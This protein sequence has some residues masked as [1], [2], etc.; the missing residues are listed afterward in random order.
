[1]DIQKA[2]DLIEKSE[3]IALLM[4]KDAS[5]DCL[6][7]AEVLARALAKKGKQTG[8]TGKDPTGSPIPEVFR[9]LNSSSDLPREFIVSLDTG[10]SP[11]SQLRYEKSENR[12]DIILS[13]KESS[14]LRDSISF[15]DGKTICDCIVSINVEN[16]EE[17]AGTINTDPD[18]FTATPIIN[19]DNGAAKK[20]YGEAN[21]VDGSRSSVS[22]LIYQFLSAAYES[23]LDPDSATI[24]LAGIVQKTAGFKTGSTS[25][26]TLLAS[27]ELMRLGAKMEDAYELTKE[28]ESLGVAQLIGR[29]SVRSRLDENQKILWSFLTKEDFEKTGRSSKDISRVLAHLDSSFP[30]HAVSASLWQDPAD[31]KVHATL[32]GERHSLEMIQS[33]DEG[34]FQSP[35]LKLSQTFDSF[36]EAEEKIAALF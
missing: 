14:V 22:E 34:E 24:L 1:M 19:I 35:Y 18:L 33:R 7:A 15:G 12:I 26:D 5:F 27:S 17:S 31:N 28:A 16:I 11:V 36:R 4:P 29:A 6:A 32:S 23:P 30:Q 8:I 20:N 21:L 3:H 25:A 13:P 10:R 2:I 9:N